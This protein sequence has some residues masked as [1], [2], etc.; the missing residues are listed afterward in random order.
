MTNKEFTLGLIQ[1][2]LERLYSNSR[3][4][5]G[6]ILAGV[7]HRPYISIST[8]KYLLRLHISTFF[9]ISNIVFT[10]AN[11]NVLVTYKQQCLVQ[12]CISNIVI[13]FSFL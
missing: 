10:F 12:L 3:A 4:R 7:N 8:P 2:G 11:S 5:I 9:K 6:T 1:I 13:A